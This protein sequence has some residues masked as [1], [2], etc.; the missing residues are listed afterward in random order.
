MIDVVYRAALI[1]VA[2]GA[3]IF[4]IYYQI[5]SGGSWRKTPMGRHVMGY[6]MAAALLADAGALRVFLPDLAGQEWMRTIAIVLAAIFVWQRDYIL[7]R[8]QHSREQQRE[9]ERTN[10]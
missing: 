3:T 5:A 10:R 1:A 4:P 6:T 8:A 9:D 7:F 2:I